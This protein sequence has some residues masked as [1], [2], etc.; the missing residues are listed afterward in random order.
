MVLACFP[1]VSP[2]GS[3]N[4]I[5]FSL[6]EVPTCERAMNSQTKFSP[7]VRTCAVRLVREY[8]SEFPSL[9]ATAQYIA[10]RIGCSTY[11]LLK[12]VQREEIE[13]A[14]R[15]RVKTERQRLKLL[16]RDL[17]ERRRTNEILKIFTAFS[18]QVRIDC[19]LKK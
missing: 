5:Y 16:K 17:E 15:L 9:W 4:E 7:E 11:T 6:E 1:Y 10:L 12:W 18:S 3:I 8:R 19:A 14:I 13:N 2:Y